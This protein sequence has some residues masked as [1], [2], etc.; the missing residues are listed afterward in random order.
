MGATHTPRRRFAGVVQPSRPFAFANDGGDCSERQHRY[1]LNV[2]PYNIPNRV[3]GSIIALCESGPIS[4]GRRR[5]V[6]LWRNGRR[7]SWQYRRS[8]LRLLLGQ[9]RRVALMRRHIGRL[10]RDI[11]KRAKR[12]IYPRGARPKSRRR[13]ILVGLNVGGIGQSCREQCHM[14]RQQE[15]RDASFGRRE[16]YRVQLHG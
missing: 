4:R 3:R 13:G 1:V 14:E 11:P 12:S 2:I 16:R 10:L 15:Y 6:G 9:E 8:P 7:L 5:S